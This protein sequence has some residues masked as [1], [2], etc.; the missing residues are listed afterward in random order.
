MILPKELISIFARI[1]ELSTKRFN[2][3]G[4]LTHSFSGSVQT[5]VILSN[6]IH[7]NEFIHWENESSLLINSRNTYR[8]MFCNS[9]NI[10]LE[11][12]RFG[13]DNPV[14]LV[15][16]FPSGKNEWSSIQPHNCN[17]DLYYAELKLENNNIILSWNVK[18][19]TENYR[20]KTRYFQ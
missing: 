5:K 20:L 6:E 13:K 3:N 1:K 12:L 15:E 8:W 16:L 10:K 2:S 14:F 17:D 11:H 18:G 4:I 7:F 9:G 19:P